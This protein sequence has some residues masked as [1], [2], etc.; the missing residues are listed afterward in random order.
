MWY[1][2]RQRQQPQQPQQQERMWRLLRLA[3]GCVCSAHSRVMWEAARP[4]SLQGRGGRPGKGGAL[5]STSTHTT[6]L[7]AACFQRV[8]RNKELH[9]A[10]NCTRRLLT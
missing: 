2:Q 4:I 8:R 5:R 7:P 10:T 3:C 9:L 1:A 6:K